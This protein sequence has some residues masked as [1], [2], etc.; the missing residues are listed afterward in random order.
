MWVIIMQILAS[1][2]NSAT[3]CELPGDGADIHGH[4]FIIDL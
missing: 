4:A 1:V 2:I 3:V